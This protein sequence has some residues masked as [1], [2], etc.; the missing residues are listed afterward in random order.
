MT[1][2]DAFLQ[3]ILED[4]DDDTPRLV[5]ADWLDEHGQ[6]ERAEFIRVQCELARLRSE[7]HPSSEA[8]VRMAALQRREDVLLGVHRR[9]WT[10]PL[11]EW[12][13]AV[14]CGFA[15]GFVV[16]VRAP[17]VLFLQHG[18]EL[19]RVAPV[20][21]LA[22]DGA[23]DRA[24]ALAASPL[25]LHL[26][27][28]LLANQR[29]DDAAARAL[30]ASSHL[31]NLTLLNLDNNRLTWE[32]AQALAASPHLQR[33][34][35]LHLGGNLLG[36]AGAWSLATSLRLP[37]LT[38]L[39]LSRNRLGDAGALALAGVAS[40]AGL[41]VLHLQSNGIG[42]QGAQALAASASLRDL[43][44]LNLGNNPINARGVR[45]L[46]SRFGSRVHL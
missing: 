29:L 30:T 8:Q 32:G 43:Q 17:V 2:D 13:R 5:Y 27:S 14:A 46:Q 34:A 31:G 7:E 3:A 45:A 11:P 19:F 12:A 10:Q 21:E 24:A 16:S 4:P 35:R 28:L 20:Q 15:R 42:E 23:G 39:Y 41:G 26:R 25:L 44:E 6:P 9:A 22:L 36:P 40:L 38:R 18:T 33:L 37:G 1:H